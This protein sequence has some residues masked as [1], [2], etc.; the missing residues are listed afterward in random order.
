VLVTQ[1]GWSRERDQLLLTCG[2][3]ASTTPAGCVTK[4]GCSDATHDVEVSTRQDFGARNAGRAGSVAGDRPQLICG[5][6]GF[7]QVGLMACR[8]R[9][10]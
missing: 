5:A 3:G 6:W 4:P 7:R 1:G 10:Q 9:R 2:F 8:D